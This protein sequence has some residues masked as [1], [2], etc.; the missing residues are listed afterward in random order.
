MWQHLEGN[1]VKMSLHSE[2]LLHLSEKSKKKKKKILHVHIPKKK[3]TVSV[4]LEQ[5]EMSVCST[6]K[7]KNPMTIHVFFAC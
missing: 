4:T 6:K 1:T 7:K 5:R 2:L 3:D